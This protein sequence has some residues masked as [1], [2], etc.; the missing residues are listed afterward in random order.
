MGTRYTGFEGY[1]LKAL[2]KVIV[3]DAKAADDYHAEV[4]KRIGKW[5]RNDRRYHDRYKRGRR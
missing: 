2:K 4:V 5:V 3:T 1:T